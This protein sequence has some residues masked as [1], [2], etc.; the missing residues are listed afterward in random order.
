MNIL[1]LSPID[2]S[3]IAKLGHYHSV[4]AP[5]QGDAI[6]NGRWDDNEAEIIILRSGI[7]LNRQRLQDMVSLKAVIRAG[8]GVDNIDTD[9]LAFRGIPLFAVVQHHAN[10]VAELTVAL[11]LNLARKIVIADK[12]MRSGTWDKRLC[13]GTEFAGKTVGLIGIGKI[14]Q[15]I[16][17][18]CLRW[19]VKVIGLVRNYSESRQESFRQLGI[20][21]TQSLNEVA[22]KADFISLQVPLQSETVN[23]IG[24]EFFTNMKKTAFFVNVGRGGT[25][26]EN[27][28]ASAL[29]T[30]LIAGAA[31]D[32]HEHEGGPSLFGQFENTLLTPHIGSS[33]V[34]TQF[35]I[36]EEIVRVVENIYLSIP[37]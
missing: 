36:G 26:D 8:A 13:T 27:A 32:V 7:P 16:A 35:K 34:E 21:L 19:D 9:Y 3:A 5:F 33:T 28:L 23:L 24:A 20:E 30:N 18:L 6:F 29:Q 1:V 10:A 4:K 11:F 14:G 25:V 22:R 31:L 17:E 15:R 37:A 2:L 12:L